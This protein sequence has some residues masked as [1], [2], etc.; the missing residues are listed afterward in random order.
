MGE[1]ASDQKLKE[2]WGFFT[3]KRFVAMHR[4]M[5][6]VFKEPSRIYIPDIRQPENNQRM[7]DFADSWIKFHLMEKIK[8]NFSSQVKEEEFDFAYLEAKEDFLASQKEKAVQQIV[9]KEPTTVRKIKVEKTKEEKAELKKPE[10]EK[11]EYEL[12]SS[13]K[14]RKLLTA[15]KAEA[16]RDKKGMGLRNEIFIDD[17]R[18]DVF[19]GRKHAAEFKDLMY[20][21]LVH[22][23]MHAGVG[24][25]NEILYIG[26]WGDAV[27]AE[28]NRDDAIQ[29]AVKRFRKILEKYNLGKVPELSRSRY[30][31]SK[32]YVMKPR[33]SH[34]ISRKIE[35][36]NEE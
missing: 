2:I 24:G 7:L 27:A 20:A 25:N 3:E 29:Q 31:A 33:P 23:V 4:F 22:F 32:T 6:K 15:E 19:V 1:F 36:D 8:K 11:A 10:G 26:V 9:F 35:E 18:K 28:R 14:K 12:L 17:E 21:M 16:I 34:C 5:C 30:S 13:G